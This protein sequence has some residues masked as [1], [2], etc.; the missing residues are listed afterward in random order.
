MPIT[1]EIIDTKITPAD[2]REVFALF[3]SLD[4]Q[5]SPFKKTSEVS[6]LNSQ[7][8]SFEDVSEE[9][10]EVL[11]LAEQTKKETQGFFDVFQGDYFN[12]SGIVKGWAIQKLAKLLKRKGFTNFYIDAGGDVEVCGK[13]SQDEFWRVGIRNPNNHEEIVKVIQLAGGGVATSGTAVRGQHIYNPHEP[14]RLITDILSMTV[15]AS[16]I[17]DADRFATA[18]FAMGA[19]GIAFIEE[20]PD[21]EGYMIDKDGVATYTSGF[22]QFVV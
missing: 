14:N 17:V 15:I 19:R 3:K 13:N 7:D 16:Q 18:A 10:K 4:A 2:F 1:V 20:Q 11:S 6:R 5:F 12:P 9:M 8:L 22:E 21:L